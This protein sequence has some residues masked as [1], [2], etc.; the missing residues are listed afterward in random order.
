MVWLIQ[1]SLHFH[2]L[3]KYISWRTSDSQIHTIK[4]A[5][6]QQKKKPIHIL[7]LCDVYHLRNEARKKKM[8]WLFSFLV[9]QNVVI[10]ILRMLIVT[11]FKSTVCVY[12]KCRPILFIYLWF[13]SR[14]YKIYQKKMKENGMEKYQVKYPF[15]Y[16][17]IETCSSIQQWCHLLEMSDKVRISYKCKPGFYSYIRVLYSHNMCS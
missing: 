9:K 10:F 1:K 4:H 17:C 8:C 14:A 5:F 6:K 3:R 15:L 16:T 13:K 12:C 11:L 2:H 7:Y